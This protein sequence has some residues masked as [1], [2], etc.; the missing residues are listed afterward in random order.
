MSNV[1]ALREQRRGRDGPHHGSGGGISTDD[2]APG[3]VE[4]TAAVLVSC[5][6][7]S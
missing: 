6:L 1:E 5:A 3:A 4:V 7:E 2:I